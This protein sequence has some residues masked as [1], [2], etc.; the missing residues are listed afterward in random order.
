MEQINLIFWIFAFLLGI[1]FSVAKLSGNIVQM[2][3]MRIAG[4]Y[5][6]IYCILKFMKVM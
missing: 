5:V 1:F 2:A 4:L 6:A 3:I